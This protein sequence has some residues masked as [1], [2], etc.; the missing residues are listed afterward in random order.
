MNSWNARWLNVAHANG[1]TIAKQLTD[2][3]FGLMALGPKNVHM[4]MLKRS[5][6]GLTWQVNGQRLLRD[7]V[8]VLHSCVA[9]GARRNAAVARHNVDEFVVANSNFLNAHV[10][11][12]AIA[13]EI[14][15]WK[16]LHKKIFRANFYFSRKWRGL[17]QR[18]LTQWS[19][20]NFARNA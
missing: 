12:F 1:E 10:Q 5:W 20:N 7:G 8:F 13:G 14:I 4:R 16:L 19:W 17:Q 3:Q 18:A 15:K 9:N 11:M 6:I 2:A